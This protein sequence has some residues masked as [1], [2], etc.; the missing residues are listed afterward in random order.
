MTP[1]IYSTTTTTNK[2]GMCVQQMMKKNNNRTTAERLGV[3]VACSFQVIS[4][5]ESLPKSSWREALL[6]KTI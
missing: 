6:A 5:I 3:I 2:K 4:C 1:S